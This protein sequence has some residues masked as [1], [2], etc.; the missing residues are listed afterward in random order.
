MAL[1]IETVD[2]SFAHP[3]M[4]RAISA[5]FYFSLSRVELVSF[6]PRK[7]HEPTS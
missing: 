7:T 3:S 2:R 1:P 6:A 4:K 5:Y